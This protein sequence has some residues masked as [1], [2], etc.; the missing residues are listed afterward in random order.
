MSVVPNT[1]N[2]GMCRIVALQFTLK[3]IFKKK[4]EEEL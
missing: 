2:K 1:T 4:K 3:N